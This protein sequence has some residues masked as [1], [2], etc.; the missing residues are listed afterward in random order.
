VK[1]LTALVETIAEV[2]EGK[3]H[4]DRENNELTKA[5]VNPEHT[6]QTRGV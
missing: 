5:L 6:G 3:F 4:P 2:R 1:P